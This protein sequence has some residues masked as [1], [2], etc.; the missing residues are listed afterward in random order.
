[1]NKR[2]KIILTAV[3]IAIPL[4]IAAVGLVKKA[5]CSYLEQEAI[6]SVLSVKVMSRAFDADLAV[7]NLA[8]EEWKASCGK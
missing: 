3:V 8:V 7:A 1:M 5:R 2:T 6:R 4:A